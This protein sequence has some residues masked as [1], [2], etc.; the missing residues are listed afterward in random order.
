MMLNLEI[1]LRNGIRVIVVTRPA[2]DYRETDQTALQGTIANLQDAGV[3]MV[4][5]PNF[6]QKFAVMDQIDCMVREYQSAELR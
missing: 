5:R 1:A 6:H 4:F 2:E 3:K